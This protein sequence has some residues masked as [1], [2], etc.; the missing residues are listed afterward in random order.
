ME[1]LLEE[2]K[3]SGSAEQ[4]RDGRNGDYI[5]P[6]MIKRHALAGEGHCIQSQTIQLNHSF[7]MTSIYSLL[8]SGIQPKYYFESE[9]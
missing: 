6:G 4:P 5:R 7:D 3:C 2:E 9:I 1:R 8:F